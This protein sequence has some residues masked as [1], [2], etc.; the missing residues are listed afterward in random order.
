MQIVK[1]ELS[2]FSTGETQ[3]SAEFLLHLYLSSFT[4][5]PSDERKIE[6]KEE[7]E[8]VDPCNQFFKKPL[9]PEQEK[10]LALKLGSTSGDTFEN[11]TI[12]ESKFDEIV[13]ENKIQKEKIGME[14]FG[15]ELTNTVNSHHL[16]C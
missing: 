10:A 15:C 8:K 2:W 3:H 1:C 14:G 13:A 12:E 6:I 4:E 7:L 11:V 5:P 16:I 9:N